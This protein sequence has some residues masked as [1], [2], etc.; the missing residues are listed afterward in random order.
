M[1]YTHSE[2]YEE[3]S[4]KNDIPLHEVKFVGDIVFNAINKNLK[5]PSSIILKIRHI[6][7]FFMRKNKLEYEIIL[8]KKKIAEGNTILEPHLKRMEERLAEYENYIS[9]RDKIKEVRHGHQK[10][11]QVDIPEE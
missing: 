3:V 1:Q 4:V 7:K 2:L 8:T 10:P 6:G 9:E 11:I 5:E